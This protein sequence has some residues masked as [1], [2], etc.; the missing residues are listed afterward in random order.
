MQ[1]NPTQVRKLD[2]FKSKMCPKT[3]YNA[4]GSAGTKRPD[5]NHL[6]AS[7]LKTL[8]PGSDFG[9]SVASCHCIR[10]LA[11]QSTTF[12]PRLESSKSKWNRFS[13]QTA[14]AVS[15]NEP[16]QFPVLSLT[17]TVC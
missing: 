9:A 2:N 17:D 8:D 13:K 15:E 11:P 12:A 7:R 1:A 14:A 6:N 10:A 3:G 5:K 16:L 4:N